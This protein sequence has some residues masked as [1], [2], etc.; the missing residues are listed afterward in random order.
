MAMAAVEFNLQKIS[1]YT[2]SAIAS[3]FRVANFQLIGCATSWATGIRKSIQNL[4][5]HSV[6]YH[7]I[8]LSVHGIPKTIDQHF[9]PYYR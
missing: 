8:L 2:F 4:L 3:I 6:E 9:I 1:R 5:T 7:N